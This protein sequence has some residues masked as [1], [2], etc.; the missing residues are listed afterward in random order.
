MRRCLRFLGC[1]RLSSERS[2]ALKLFSLPSGVSRGLWGERTTWTRW[3][4]SMSHKKIHTLAIHTC[5]NFCTF[6]PLVFE[7]WKFWQRQWINRL[8]FFVLFEVRSFFPPRDKRQHRIQFHPMP[9]FVQEDFCWHSVLYTCNITWSRCKLIWLFK[10][11]PLINDVIE[12]R[13]LVIFSNERPLVSEYHLPHERQ[14]N[15][16]PA[17]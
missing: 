2:G 4:A 11:Q 8:A 17:T 6:P 15:L 9:S 1:V 10:R 13:F 7:R 12:C 5:M 14:K 16:I 3:R